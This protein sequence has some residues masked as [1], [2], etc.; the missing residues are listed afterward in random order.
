METNVKAEVPSYK[1]KKVGFF[2]RF[3]HNK[4]ALVALGILLIIF[5]CVIFAPLV[6]KYNPAHSDLSARL[7]PPGT[8]SRTGMGNHILGTD[9]LGRDIFARLLYG[10]RVSLNVGFTV[11]TIGAIIGVTLGMI[12]GYFG[13]WTDMIIMRLVDVW[14]SSPTL[15]VALTFVMVLGPGQ[16]N[17][18]LA[19]LINSW[20]LFCRMARS[21][22]LVLRSSDMV[23]AGRAIG[24]S[25]N[26]IL[27][28]HIMPNIIS[29]LVTT[30]ILEL[31]HFINAE[32][33]LSFLGFGVQP[34]QTSWG[35]LIGEGRRY[36]TQAWWIVL[37]PGIA[38]GITVLC[39]NLVGN[40]VRD[41]FDP[42]A[43]KQ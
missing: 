7:S 30:Y 13:G 27:F 41:E 3:K 4:A 22:V 28:K 35:L 2:R 34:P 20:T 32:A 5:L 29:P 12:A 23:E 39:L 11:A 8:P 31:A 21:Q 18:I 10:G 1:K 26:R 33:N 14:A 24:A 43:I 9:Q 15:L 40:W 25:T 19:L 16:K 36:L 38:I 42:L 37:F 6:T 17:L